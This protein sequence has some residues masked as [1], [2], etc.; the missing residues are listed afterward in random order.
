MGLQTGE[1]AEGW[2]NFYNRDVY[3]DNDCDIE[4][5]AELSRASI[6]E[7]IDN[8]LKNPKYCAKFFYNKICSEWMNPSFD[9][10]NEIQRITVQNPNT[11]I[12]YSVPARWFLHRS[13]GK[14]LD[15][16][17]FILN[18]YLRIYE[19]A[20]FAGTIL[21][22]IIR[23]LHVTDCFFII[24]FIGG[25]MFHIFWEA[26]CQYMLPYFVLLI[27]YGIVGLKDFRDIITDNVMR[28]G[29]YH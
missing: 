18:E 20:V 21:Y 11:W 14:S 28:P 25:F 23:R 13:P 9:A 10:F 7:S 15:A 22:L 5:A 4:K 17:H 3:W 29:I 12:H 1:F 8:F 2:N 27:P 19:L 24:V 6:K 26:A 16:T